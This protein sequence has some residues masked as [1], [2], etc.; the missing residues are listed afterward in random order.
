MLVFLDTEFTNF[1]K[2]ELLSLALVSEDGREFYAERMDYDPTACSGFVRDTVLPLF[3]RVPG[4]ACDREQFTERV[5]DWLQQ[6]PA[7]VT[8]L[9]DFAGDRDLL[10]WIASGH[11]TADLRPPANIAQKIQLGENTVCDPVFEHAAALTYT[12]DWPQHHALADARALMAGYR[13]WRA[14]IEGVWA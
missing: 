1:L 12:D 5:R 14:C 2:P 7:P 11:P 13:A 4:A 10:T 6:L 3:G 8:V 9:Y